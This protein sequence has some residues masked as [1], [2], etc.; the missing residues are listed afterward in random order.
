MNTSWLSVYLRRRVLCLLGLGFSS[1]LPLALTGSTLQAWMA[2]EKV[3]I[4]LIGIFSLV[5]L[6]YT[7]KIVWAPLM[8]RFTPPWLGR[9]RGWILVTQLLLAGTIL[10]LGTFSPSRHLM[11]MGLLAL[12][13]AFLSASQ[14]IVIDAY[15]ADVLPDREKGAGAATSVVGYRLAMLTSGALALILSDHLPW[16][17]VY[18]LMA[19]AMG[20][21][22]LFAFVSPE[23]PHPRGAVPAS[24]REAVW[25]PLADYFKRSGAVEMLA[26]IMVF[27]LG[28]AIA[29]AMT[30]PFLLDIGFTRTEVGT[31][32]KAFGLAAT[33]VGT[34]AGGGIIA[35]MGIHRSLWIFAFLQ[36]VSNL[37]FTGLA[38][39]GHNYPAMVGAVAVE[40][41]CGGLG[42]A[43]FLA[44][45]MS[46]CDKRYTATQFA[47]LSSLMAVTRVLAGAPTGFLVS[48]LGW[49]LFYAVSTLGALPGI[50]L[51]P[52]FAPWKGPANSA[53]AD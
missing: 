25:M 16:R 14:D 31:V 11:F 46:L 20:A 29:G 33:I 36:A 35:R 24:L 28:D 39:L 44:F 6:P 5:G 37:G 3:D 45:L 22:A 1:G 50:L 4:R 51:L 15:R 32:N 34:L 27:K 9:R 48:S 13:V 40:N 21:C 2:S 7:L 43:A 38:L 12:S 52:R 18:G 10:A 53:A 41:I 19:A 47:L 49:P 17:H 30:T 26:F 23:P 8:D 42:T